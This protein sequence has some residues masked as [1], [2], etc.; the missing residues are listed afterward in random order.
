V[1]DN[2]H[3]LVPDPPQRTTGMIFIIKIETFNTNFWSTALPVNPILCPEWSQLIIIDY[4]SRVLILACQS[5][6]LDG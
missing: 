2:G 6:D 3:N 1:R 4:R 5:S